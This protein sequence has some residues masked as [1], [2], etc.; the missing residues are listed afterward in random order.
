[1]QSLP[2]PDAPVTTITSGSWEERARYWEAEYS[3][4]LERL[5]VGVFTQDLEGKLISANAGGERLSGFQREQLSGM[6]MRQ[7]LTVDS[8][9]VVVALVQN[10]IAG[11][12]KCA[13]Q[14]ELLH[15][16]GSVVPVEIDVMIRRDREQLVGIQY[17]MRDIGARKRSEES[18]RQ[19]EQRFRLMA[20]NMTEMILAYDMD[21]RLIFANPA[22]QNLTGYS[23]AELE[24]AQFICWIHPQDQERMLNYW[25][26]LYEGKSF[27]EEQYRLTTKDGRLKW[28]EASWGPI[29]D[30]SGVQVGVQGRER[31][32]TERKLA[33]ETLRQTEQRLRIDEAHYRTLFEDSPFPMWEE[34][35]SAVKTYVDSLRR[36]GVANLKSYLAGRQEAVAECLRRVKVVDI[37][38]AAREF[39]GA[40]SKEELMGDLS[41]IFDEQAYEIFREEIAA[42]ADNNSAYK[43]E[44]QTRTLAGEERTVSMI[45]SLVGAPSIDW[46]R[47]IVSFFD[48]T[49]RKRLEEEFVQAQKLESLGRMAGGIAHDFNNLLTVI[50]GY[51]ELLLPELDESHPLREGLTQIKRA[52]ARG[53]ELTQQLLAFGRKQVSQPNPCSLNASIVEIQPM[54]RRV[55]G[56]N[57]QLLISLDAS[58]GTVKVDRSQM[59][60]VLM[61]LAVNSQEAMPDGGK[62]TIETRNVWLG[63]SVRDTPGEPGARPFVLLEVRDT[64][65]GMDERTKKHLFDPF[66]TTKGIGKGSG[67]GLSTVFGIVTQSG[68]HISVSS[69]PGKGATF[70]VY[71][72]WFDGPAKVEPASNDRRQNY[73]GTGAVLVVEDQDEVRKLV[74]YLLRDF[75]FEVLVAVDGNEA[76]RIVER[77][78]QTIR[79]L[80]TDV[81]MPGM[82]GRELAGRLT[83]LQP[84]VKVIY[85]SGYADQLMGAGGIIDGSIAYLQKPF[86]EDK[87]VRVLRQVLE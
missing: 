49:D 6:S 2:R 21:R 70:S 68:G 16:D 58:L 24:E 62:L 53:A 79:L 3:S 31:D 78:P 10:A 9:P 1:V 55:I 17:L 69:E 7:L 86:T 64:G 22:A 84:E 35:F 56:E 66:F 15:S 81:V 38:R 50:N 83:R 41:K 67:L 42:L 8:Y 57:I 5:P 13:G 25:D 47:V 54:L 20:K 75:G 30:E 77:H 37:N 80:L 28:I 74:C 82:N 60:Q 11:E 61:N 76:L 52:G 27:H 32:I 45:V 51:S 44:F 29:L 36:G 33:E 18:V 39:Y 87:L 4:L 65:I 85:M 59:H 40:S 73:R 14:A 63:S 43:A 72:P 19:D 71:L 34:D 26:A 12:T 46:S 23:V 48:I